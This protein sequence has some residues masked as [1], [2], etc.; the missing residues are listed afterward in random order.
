MTSHHERI[1][2]NE[3]AFRAGNERAHAWEERR[4]D[5]PTEQ[6]TFL[7]ECGD[8]DC[9]GRIK[10]TAAEYEDVR[11]DDMRFAVLV[12]HELPDAE[13]VMSEH[14]G[15]YLVVEKNED[16]RGIVEDRFG[17]RAN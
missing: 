3:A 1:A 6:H 2:F 16:V 15:R 11:S 14:D 13:R 5:P 4:D 9:K 17:P 12:G 10:M 8:P 7:C